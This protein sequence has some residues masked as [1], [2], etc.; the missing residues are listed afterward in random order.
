M[1]A[2]CQSTGGVKNCISAYANQSGRLL[3]HV[4]PGD[5]FSLPW[6]L[7]NTAETHGGAA[8]PFTTYTERAFILTT[9][10]RIDEHHEIP[11]IVVWL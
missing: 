7:T 10:V 8:T 1:E 6:A 4:K 2:A 11:I 5:V 9:I 3:Y